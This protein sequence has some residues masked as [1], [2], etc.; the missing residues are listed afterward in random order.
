MHY[1][2]RIKIAQVIERETGA[3]HRPGRK[4]QNVRSLERMKI[5]PEC[6]ERRNRVKQQH[7]SI[8]QPRRDADDKPIK[9]NSSAPPSA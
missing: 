4:E 2:Q 7:E 5:L 8:C 9:S 1:A 6:G 3:K